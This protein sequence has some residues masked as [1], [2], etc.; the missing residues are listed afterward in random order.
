MAWNMNQQ[1]RFSLLIE[2]N[3]VVFMTTIQHGE[4]IQDIEGNYYIASVRRMSVDEE[5]FSTGLVKM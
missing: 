2:I 4:P 1:K 3:D 5:L